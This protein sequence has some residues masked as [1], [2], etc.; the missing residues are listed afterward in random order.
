MNPKI[1]FFEIE[2]DEKTYLSKH[3]RKGEALYTSEKLSVENVSKYKDAVVI[4]PFIGSK[5][6][7]KII[8]HLP[9]LKLIATRSTGYDH[10]PLQECKKKG[11]AIANV[12][13]YGEY[14]VAEHTF[15]LILTLSRNIHKAYYRMKF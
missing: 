14:T 7:K 13:S 9:R 15:G 12:P 4:S 5:I 1:I 3:F 8:Q 10:I 11:I 6:D 2:P